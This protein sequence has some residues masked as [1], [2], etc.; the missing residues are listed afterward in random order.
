MGVKA[1]VSSPRKSGPCRPGL[2][3]RMRE[4]AFTFVLLAALVVGLSLA[5]PPEDLPETPYDESEELPYDCTPLFC[6]D[7]VL[8]SARAPQ[9]VSQP[10]SLCQLGSLKETDKKRTEQFDQ[11]RHATFDSFTFLNSPLRC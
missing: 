7:V 2:G 9:A 10:G 6:I 1:I 11:T 3:A 5:I 4:C 8:E